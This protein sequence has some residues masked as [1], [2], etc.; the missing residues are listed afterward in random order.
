M[1][2]TPF[3]F[4]PGGALHAL[5]PRRVS[6]LAFCVANVLIDVEPLYFMVTG[7]PHLHRFFHTYVGATLM[8]LL[9]VALFLAARRLALARRL[10][11]PFEWQSLG[12]SA[13]GVGA[14]AGAW[15]HVLLDSV[16]HADITPLA[17]F[18]DAN[19]LYRVVSLAVLHGACVACGVAAIAAIALRRR[20]ANDRGRVEFW[21]R[22]R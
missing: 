6:F 16:M 7:Q 2:V 20:V 13:V 17:P 12:V 11:D 9:T 21:R 8:A 22:K 19:P 15:S 4:G 5:A 10:P 14:L 18:S 3:H 1:P